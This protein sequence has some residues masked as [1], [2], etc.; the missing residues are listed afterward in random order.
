MLLKENLYETFLI[1]MPQQQNKNFEHSPIYNK[2][3]K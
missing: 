3:L 1:R 2:S